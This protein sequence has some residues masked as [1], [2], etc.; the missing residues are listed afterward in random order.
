MLYLRF[1]LLAATFCVNAE[2]ATDFTAGGV[3]GLLNSLA[4][5]EATRAEVCSFTVFLEDMLFPLSVRGKVKD[6]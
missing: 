6:G 2:A 4:A 1:A 3:L 5:V